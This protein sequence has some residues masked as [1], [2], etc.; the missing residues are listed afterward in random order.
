MVVEID[1]AAV[2]VMNDRWA[3]PLKRFCVCEK[4]DGNLYMYNENSEEIFR[5]IFAKGF[6]GQAKK[7]PV[8][9]MTLTRLEFR[10]LDPV[11]F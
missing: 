5:T 8:E 1:T 6:K 7:R 9:D 10:A 11:F 3:D 2:T 4:A